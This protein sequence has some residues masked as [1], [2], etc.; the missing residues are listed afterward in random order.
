MYRFLLA[1][2]FLLAACATTGED[3]ERNSLALKKVEAAKVVID[4]WA[5]EG[6]IEKPDFSEKTLRR[7]V[8]L[9]DTAFIAAAGNPNAEAAFARIE[10]QC[11]LIN[12]AWRESR[13][14]KDVPAT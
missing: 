1:I 12:D 11:A 10:D 6:L 7:L 5:E 13:A 14:E 9:C 8:I 4:R 3:G 2:P